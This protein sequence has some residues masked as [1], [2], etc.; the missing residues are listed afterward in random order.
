MEKQSNMFPP[1]VN[2]STAKYLNISEVD[3][4][5]N[6]KIKR[7]MR[8]MMNKIKEDMYKHLLKSKKIK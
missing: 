6:N 2:N 3:E 8:R 7:T 4:I 1:R 5:S